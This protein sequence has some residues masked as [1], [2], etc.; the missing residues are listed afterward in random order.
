MGIFKD[1]QL[2][3]NRVVWEVHKPSSPQTAL[4]FNAL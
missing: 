1:N 3:F 4:I 2:N